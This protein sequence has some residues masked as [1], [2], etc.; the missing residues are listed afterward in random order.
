MGSGSAGT[1]FFYISIDILPLNSQF[2]TAHISSI[3]AGITKST[4][5][6]PLL[7]GDGLHG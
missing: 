3:S 2:V 1:H 5:N 7:G 6:R 4:D